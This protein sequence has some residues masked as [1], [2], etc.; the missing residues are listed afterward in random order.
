MNLRRL[1]STARRDAGQAGQYG[2][3]GHVWKEDGGR[4][5][6]H[7]LGVSCSQTVYVCEECGCHDYGDPGGPAHHECANECPHEFLK[8]KITMEWLHEKQARLR[9]D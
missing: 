6:P 8:P 9:H 1:I 5:C 4:T 7:D 2:N 3:A